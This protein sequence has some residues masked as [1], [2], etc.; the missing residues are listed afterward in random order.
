MANRRI[1]DLT[2]TATSPAE[3]D[4]LVLDGNANSTRKVVADYFAAVD[5][6]PAPTPTFTYDP[7]SGVD[8]IV[9]N[10]PNNWKDMSGIEE[11]YIGSS[12]TSIG[13]YAFREC[14][15]LTGD[16]VIPNTVTIIRQGAFKSC[17]GLSGDLVI[18]NSVISI[19]GS[20]FDTCTGFSGDLVIPNS[21]TSIGT[22]A[23]KSCTGFSGDLVFP[24]SVTTI[25]SYAF[26]YCTGLT[27]STVIPNSATSIGSYAFWYCG[28]LTAAYLNQPI[29][30]IGSDAF[31]S[32]GIINVYIGPNATGY[33]PGSGQTIGGKSGITVSTW[34]NYPNFP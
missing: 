26:Y 20:V 1:K 13:N 15:D 11:L 28:G 25:G 18:P 3:D 7:G 5:D 19:Q 32:S 2:T 9:G 17:V 31:Q 14:F 22:F 29:S 24:N 23:F 4:F 33:T 8:F 6:L 12:V 30:S 27:G 16:L 10:I 34:T 21:V